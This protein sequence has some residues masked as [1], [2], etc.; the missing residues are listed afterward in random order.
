MPA[1]P[2]KAA[3]EKLGRR[4]KEWCWLMTG[5][6]RTATMTAAT[7]D[8]RAPSDPRQAAV[9]RAVKA[10]A[11]A[12]LSREIGISEAL[13]AVAAAMGGTKG[14]KGEA[15]TPREFAAAMRRDHRASIVAEIVRLENEG[16]GRAAAMILAR[17]NAADP[18]DPVEIETLANRYRRWRRAEKRAT[19]RLP[20]AQRCR[21]ES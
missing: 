4:P 2:A 17:A 19:A 14:E 13:A 15:A 8:A 21:K 18:R 5:L 10:A 11:L 12:L 1:A 9:E 3:K 7:I 6:A 20:A 16:R